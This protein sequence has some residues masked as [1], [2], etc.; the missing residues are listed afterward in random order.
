MSTCHVTRLGDTNIG[1]DGRGSLRYC[2]TRSNHNAGSDTIDFKVIGT[3]QLTSPLPDLAS[4][5][6]ILGPGADLLAVSGP[7]MN[8][9][10]EKS[11]FVVLQGATVTLSGLTITQ[12]Y[13]E[14]S[15]AGVRNLGTVLLEDCT[16]SNNYNWF[17]G[18]GGLGGGIRNEGTMIITGSTISGNQVA[19]ADTDDYG[20]GIYNDPSGVL[21]IDSSTVSGNFVD[22]DGHGAGIYNAG[23]LDVRF[24][25][26]TD[27]YLD[28]CHGSGLANGGL[29]NV[30]D[31][32]IAGN[33]GASD[34]EG[35]YT[36][37]ANLIGGDPMLGP[38]AYNGGPTE[39]HAV[40]PGSPALDAGDN[41]GAP[42]WDQRGPGF[43]RIVNGTIDIGSYEAQNTDVPGSGH[44][45]VVHAALAPDPQALLPESPQRQGAQTK[46]RPSPEPFGRP[47]LLDGA[48]PGSVPVRH[49]NHSTNPF[50]PLRSRAIPM[51]VFGDPLGGAS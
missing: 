21:Q 11:I 7:G 50:A 23:S 36:G 3:I 16:V 39:T 38:L 43:P 22:V 34:V 41:T 30:Y 29:A 45:G 49:L 37:S 33:S 4:D 15:A 26:I 19:Y 47:R 12:G 48:P 31:T 5:I 27:N 44:V 14:G 9:T 20:G 32:I 35:A 13:E 51:D 42:E 10:F 18:P 24:S 28:C 40:L 2:I 17:G 46:L 25:T 6:S 1:H 8:G